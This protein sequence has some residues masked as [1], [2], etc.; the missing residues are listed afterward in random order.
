M[1]V[2]ITCYP[3]LIEICG[4]WW[5]DWIGFCTDFGFLLNQEAGK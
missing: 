1:Y 5:V 3:R 4:S 2:L